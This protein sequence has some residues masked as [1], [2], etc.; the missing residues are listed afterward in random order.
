MI[1]Q[2]LYNFITISIMCSG[3]ALLILVVRKLIGKNSGAWWRSIIWL[4]LLIR[5]CIPVTIQS[6]IGIMNHVI[7]TDSANTI[8]NLCFINASR[9]EYYFGQSQERKCRAV[10]KRK[11]HT[12]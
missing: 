7:D 6:P 8:Q 1:S 3:V 10:G 5:L 9:A 11:N 4:M 2:I 12:A